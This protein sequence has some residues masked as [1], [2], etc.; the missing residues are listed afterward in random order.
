MLQVIIGLFLIVVALALAVALF[1]PA[2]VPVQPGL[3]TI[4]NA[5]VGGIW[6][7]SPSPSS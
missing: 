5:I 4:C 6:V 7:G 2:R 1:R 3:E